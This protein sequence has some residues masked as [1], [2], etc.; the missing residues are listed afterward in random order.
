MKLI[1]SLT[2]IMYIYTKQVIV[3]SVEL[4]H[5]TVLFSYDIYNTMLII[6]KDYEAKITP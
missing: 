1:S 2:K 3:G 6:L 4:L 5:D